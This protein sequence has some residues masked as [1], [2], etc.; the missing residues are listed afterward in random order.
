MH[1][2]DYPHYYTK[3][4]KRR[5]VYY[6]A[7]ARDLKAMGWVREEPKPAK[8]SV[9]EKPA[10]AQ[11]PTPEPIKPEVVV[12]EVVT[13]EPA[14]ESEPVFE[15]MTRPELLKYAMD[16]GVDL[17]NNALKA[18]LIDACKAIK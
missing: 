7:E 4:G 3:D 15:F 17:P 16:R 14:G 10:P 5:A 13:E 2:R 9:T 11:E 18:E 1:L 12:P 8:P 6:T